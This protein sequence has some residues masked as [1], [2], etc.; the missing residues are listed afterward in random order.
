MNWP[1]AYGF[2][3]VIWVLL[4]GMILRTLS[5]VL[6]PGGL[7]LILMLVAASFAAFVTAKYMDG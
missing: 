7:Q 1:W 3:F 2:S 6:S 4:L 5:L